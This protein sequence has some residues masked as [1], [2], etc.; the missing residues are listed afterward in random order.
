MAGFGDL[1][2][3]SRLALR[4]APALLALALFAAAA[5]G[6]RGRG[7]TPDPEAISRR[8]SGLHAITVSGTVRDNAGTAVAGATV[9]FMDATADGGTGTAVTTG[10]DGHYSV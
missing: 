3:V 10:T 8:P 1:V 4:R 9:T 2:V 5:T 6:C 7:S